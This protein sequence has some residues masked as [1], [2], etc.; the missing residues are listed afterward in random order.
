MGS[1]RLWPSETRVDS[2]G[3]LTTILTDETT[4]LSFIMDGNPAGLL[5]LDTHDRLDEAFQ[6]G[7]Q[8]T[9]PSGPGSYQQT[10]GSIPRLLGDNDLH[11]SGWMAFPS[12]GVAF[13]AGGDFL[14]QSGQTTGVADTF[15]LGQYRGLI[16]GAASLGP[17]VLGLEVRNME[18]NNAY[19]PGIYSDKTLPYSLQ[20]GSSAL[21]QTYLRAGLAT[22]FPEN[23]GP[24]DAYWQAGGLFEAQVAGG[25]I[26]FNANL[27]YPGGNTFALR[28]NNSYTDYYYFGPELRY[29]IPHHAIFRFSYFLT[30]DDTNFERTVSAT[31][32]DYANL[33]AYHS[34][35]Y[36]SMNASGA[37][38]LIFPTSGRENLKI[39]GFISSFFNNTDDLSTVENVYTN[40]NRQ[41]IQTN[42][43]VGLE[44][45]HDYAFGIQFESQT[46]TLDN[47]S[48]ASAATTAQSDYNYYQFALG[49]E[50]WL[51]DHLAFRLGLSGEDDEYFQASNLENLVALLNAGLGWEDTTWACDLRLWVGEQTNLQDSSNQGNLGGFEVSGTVFL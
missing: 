17:L 9:Q 28:Q 20:N 6:W 4:D 11:Y 15:T 43:G 44:T 42:L 32:P 23:Q 33:N 36:Q 27:D 16:R 51:D 8:N 14:S 50:K 2:T 34:T 5:L 48:I 29:V 13:Q 45:I 40:T 26:A 21:N 1:G 10:Y 46:Y 22:T 31:S 38:R 35:Q 39:G 37:F 49:G 19:D 47:T 30:Y 24:D 3:G 41:Q 12:K 18:S 25:N 7:Q